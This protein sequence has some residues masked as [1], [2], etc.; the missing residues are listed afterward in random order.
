M[1][2]DTPKP[3]YYAVIFTSKKS[4][5]VEGYKEMAKLMSEEARKQPGFLGEENAEEEIGITVSYWDSIESIKNWKRHQQH[6][7]AQIKGMRQWY[8]QYK[9]RI[10][11]V[12]NDYDFGV[13]A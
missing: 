5:S 10:S 13:E 4:K 9:T 11:L 2:A 1:I 3:P 8:Q 6:V 7:S 12:E